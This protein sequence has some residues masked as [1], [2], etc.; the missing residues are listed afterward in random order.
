MLDV[1]E[2]YLNNDN[3]TTHIPQETSDLE[4]TKTGMDIVYKRGD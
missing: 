3:Y 4:T 1:L 2:L